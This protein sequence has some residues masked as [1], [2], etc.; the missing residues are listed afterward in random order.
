MIIRIRLLKPVGAD[1]S[2]SNARNVGAKRTT[3]LI[4]AS[5]FTY[6]I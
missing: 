3:Q 1:S 6:I 2:V 4:G 5:E